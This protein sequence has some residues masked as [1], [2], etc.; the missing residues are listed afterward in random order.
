MRAILA[1]LMLACV[2]AC[3][4]R[5]VEVQT[6]TQT[7]TSLNLTVTNNAT[8]AVNVYVVSGGQD[9]FV[10][11]VGANSTQTLS[12]SGVAAG[13]TVSLRARPVDDPGGS[14]WRKDNVV[15]SGATTWQVP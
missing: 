8:R 6:G 14:G 4:P 2:T 11:Q 15:L 1:V 12:V 9:I 13:S 5:R 10:G 7:V 3:G